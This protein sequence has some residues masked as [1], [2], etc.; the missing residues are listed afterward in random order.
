VA[1]V[2]DAGGTH[3]LEDFGR[4]V[5]SAPRKTLAVEK[6]ASFSGLTIRCCARALLKQAGVSEQEIQDPWYV[7]AAPRIEAA[8]IFDSS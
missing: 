7:K 8:D 5:A 2:P 4:N 3:V 1:A 6:A